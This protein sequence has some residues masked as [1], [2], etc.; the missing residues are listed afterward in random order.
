MG[1]LIPD[2][3]AQGG[4]TGGDPFLGI[5]PII[6][7]FVIFYFL[8]IRPQQKRAKEHKKMVEGL[9]KGDEVVTNGGLL[10]R[11]TKVGDH[12]VT[13]EIADSLEVRVQR[14]AVAALMPKGTMKSS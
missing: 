13:L 10:G 1:F 9:S 3:Y 14:N 12:F 8:L 5:L 4:G 6:F 2:A 11:I 7:L